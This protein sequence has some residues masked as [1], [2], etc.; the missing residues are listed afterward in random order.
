MLSYHT[1]QVA[2]YPAEPEQKQLRFVICMK[3]KSSSEVF[4]WRTDGT[5]IE[6]VKDYALI[7]WEEAV[8]D[9][10]V[11]WLYRSGIKMAQAVLLGIHLLTI[12]KN[13]LYIGGDIQIIVVHEN[14]MALE[15]PNEVRRL[16]QNIAKFNTA[17]AKLILACPD[18]SIEPED[19]Q[20]LL[21]DF[22]REAIRLHHEYCDD[23]MI[24]STLRYLSSRTPMNHPYLK[25]PPRKTLELC[26]QAVKQSEANRPETDWDWVEMQNEARRFNITLT[27]DDLLLDSDKSEGQP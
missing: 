17:I 22:V 11:K 15:D 9:H 24:V 21:L 16:E 5:T 18:T 12:A 6:S 27:K 3:G 23:A 2:F 8:Y 19:F 7:G 20:V 14:G 10:E 4:L 13:S 1:R 25:I 26:R